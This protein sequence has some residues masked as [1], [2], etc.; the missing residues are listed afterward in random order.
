MAE[1]LLMFTK[2]LQRNQVLEGNV[3]S[4]W[5]YKQH[6]YCKIYHCSPPSFQ[7]KGT[8]RTKW[9]NKEEVQ[10]SKTG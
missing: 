9:K 1:N 5:N 6:E 2:L 10:T 4:L 8:E 7:Q 3:K